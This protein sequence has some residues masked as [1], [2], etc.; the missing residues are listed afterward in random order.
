MSLDRQIERI[1]DESDGRQTLAVLLQLSHPEGLAASLQ[2]AA[3]EAVRRGVVSRA[4]DLLPPPYPERTGAEYHAASTLPLEHYETTRLIKSWSAIQSES[5]EV[6]SKACTAPILTDL[7]LAPRPGARAKNQPLWLAHA[8][9]LEV[10]RD[11]LRAV[12]QALNASAVFPNR[13]FPPPA[14]EQTTGVAP[15][16][17][18]IPYTWGLEKSGA[19]ACW[20]A[21]S[22]RGQGV[23]VAVLDTGI[24]RSHPDLNRQLLQFAEFDRQGKLVAEGLDAAHDDHGHGTHVCGIIT[25]GCASGR[26]IGMAPEARLLVARVLDKAGGT[27][28][29]ILAGLAWAVEQGADIVNLSLGNL[30]FEPDVLDT[31]TTAI[32][33][34]R[35]AGVS[36]VTAMGN[37]GSQTSGAPA[38]DYFALAVGATDRHDQVAGFSA[39]RAQVVTRS[40]FFEERHLPFVYLKPELSAPGVDIASA[41]RTG[42]WR[43]ASGTSMAAPHVTGALALLLSH[44][45]SSEL[46]TAGLQSLKGAERVRTLHALL[47]GSVE[48]LGEAGQDQRFG[49]G[50]LDVLSAYAQAVRLGYLPAPVW[51]AVSS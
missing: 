2:H 33:N 19:L 47:I 49:W 28:A 4:S 8:L 22:A 30:S 16:I 10:K 32:F 50:R 7:G 48:P 9:S 27:D 17:E 1:L 13:T 36:V 43:Y 12:S 23:K 34:A 51:K 29:Q 39:G 6:L 44:P 11:A 24:H 5:V 41:D 42:K 37:H 14:T 46:L 15:E 21:F 35:T 20:G 40:A 25:G 31:Y 3:S 26:W 38:N 45:E 18:P